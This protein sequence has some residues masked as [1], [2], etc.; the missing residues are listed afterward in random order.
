MDFEVDFVGT[1][2]IDYTQLYIE[3]H[4][5]DFEKFALEL[6]PHRLKNEHSFYNL[7]KN[8]SE[9]LKLLRLIKQLENENSR[10]KCLLE[11]FENDKL[12]QAQRL[13]E[14]HKE[15][16]ALNN[17]LAKIVSENQNLKENL[18]KFEKTKKDSP[19]FIDQKN[20]L[21][22]IIQA[23]NQLKQFD[24]IDLFKKIKEYCSA[25]AGFIHYKLI[26]LAK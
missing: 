12:F 13:K 7:I 3:R 16:S 4:Q 25:I 10:L 23:Q 11:D 22:Q 17:A 24:T 6:T 5:K 19:K 2:T 20:E 18:Q 8:K 1:N 15:K 26:R 14:L 21:Y 9:T